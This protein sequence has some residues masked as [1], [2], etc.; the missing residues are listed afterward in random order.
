ML[1]FIG[2][3]RFF[4]IL[5]NLLFFQFLPVFV[6]FFLFLV[7]FPFREIIDFIDHKSRLVRI[8]VTGK[9]VLKDYSARFPR[10]LGK[11]PENEKNNAANRFFATL[12]DGNCFYTINEHFHVRSSRSDGGADDLPAGRA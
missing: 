1:G 4:R 2:T 11:F 8:W 5:H 12:I 10:L 3:I 9:V 7:I 6:G